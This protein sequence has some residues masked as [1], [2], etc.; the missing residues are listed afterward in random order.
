MSHV[1]NFR[2]FTAT[3]IR[4]HYVTET[5]DERG[6]KGA[7]AFVVILYVL[8]C[9]FVDGDPRTLCECYA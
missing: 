3:I 9:L 8:W 7:A 6:E 5:S 1:C 2:H 4:G